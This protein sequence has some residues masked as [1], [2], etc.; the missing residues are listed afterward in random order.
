[1]SEYFSRTLERPLFLA[2]TNRA[3]FILRNK[4]PVDISV[5]VMTIHAA[6]MNLRDESH[7]D[8]IRLWENLLRCN[9]DRAQSMTTFA[10]WSKDHVDDVRSPRRVNIEEREKADGLLD[11]YEG[12]TLSE[13]VRRNLKRCRQANQLKF[14]SGDG[15][16]EAQTI[17]V[18]EASMVSLK[19]RDHLMMAFPNTP[20]LWV[21]DGAQL[22]PITAEGEPPGSVVDFLEPTAELTEIMRQQGDD[23]PD[24]PK[25]I[26]LLANHIRQMA[27][28]FIFPYADRVDSKS[29]T[30]IA[31]RGGVTMGMLDRFIEIIENDGIVLCWRNDTRQSINRKIR[32]RMGREGD[33]RWLP[34]KGERLIVAQAPGQSARED[35][36]DPVTT[37][38][39]DPRCTLTKG[40]LITLSEDAEI[41]REGEGQHTYC[42]VRIQSDSPGFGKEPLHIPAGPFLAT[43][44]E[45]EGQEYAFPRKGWFQFDYGT[46]ATVHKAQGSQFPAVGVYE[47]FPFLPPTE[48]QAAQGRF[49]SPDPEQH[50]KWLYTAVSRATDRLMVVTERKRPRGWR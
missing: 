40:E 27:V 15:A 13:A 3:A 23:H 49:P 14:D 11:S 5:S 7:A 8:A 24:S 12:K 31:R 36:R 20:I 33:V 21:G 4:L 43:Y 17:V 35:A 9:G 26:A 25:R 46:C 41:I 38:E 48:A 1:M 47:Q 16:L 42:W 6:S 28:P 37:F 45:H 30:I 34:V 2:P 50:R 29:L 18:D 22:P 10:Q 39:M 19:M 32:H 44:Q